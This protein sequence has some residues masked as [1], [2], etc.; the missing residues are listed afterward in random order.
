M[1]Q[2]ERELE[3]LKILSQEGYTTVHRLSQLLYTSESSVRRCLALLENQGVVKRSYGGVELVRATMQVLPFSSRAHHNMEAKKIMARKAVQQVQD[4]NV[5]FL[6]QSSSALFVAEELSKKRN[7]T[8]VTNN[9]KIV[10]LLSQTDT[11]VICCGG[12][13][14]ET[15]RNCLLGEDAHRIFRE[16]QAD[17]MFFSSKALSQDGV[18]YDCYREE[19]CI[20]RTMMEQARRQIFLCA[21]EKFG[22]TAPYRQCTLEELDMM[23]T[24]TEDGM[25]MAQPPLRK[26]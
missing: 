5:I 25:E 21:S 10:S 22:Q 19:V 18:V 11:E 23:I 24:E 12:K 4:G 2:S 26:P 14:S 3:I 17:V 1:Y 20:R 16:I 6:D 8:I 9:I 7:V 15:N 13:L